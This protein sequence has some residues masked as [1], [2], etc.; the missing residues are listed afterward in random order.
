MVK[1]IRLKADSICPLALR[2]P[3]MTSMTHVSILSGTHFRGSLAEL[4]RD[5]WRQEDIQRD[6]VREF[7]H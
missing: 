3:S 7:T 6:K 4:G 5:R 2:E 1:K